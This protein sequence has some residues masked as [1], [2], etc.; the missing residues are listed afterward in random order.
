[1]ETGLN[2]VTK[3]QTATAIHQIDAAV[4]SRKWS[5]IITGLPS[6]V[7]NENQEVTRKQVL[8][9]GREV[10]QVPEPLISACHRLSKVKNAAIIIRFVDLLD[11]DRWLS[12]AGQLK[13][14]KPN[15]ASVGI[16]P[17]LPPILTKARKDIFTKRAN[18]NPADKSRAKVKYAAQF[19]YIFMTVGD[20]NNKILPNMTKE[21]LALDFFDS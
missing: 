2:S 18:L 6:S 12:R 20:N 11:R 15:N 9:L 3:H 8:K 1:M 14:F 10:L 4:Y 21:D 16:S 13:T 5:L 17:N 19:P 7:E